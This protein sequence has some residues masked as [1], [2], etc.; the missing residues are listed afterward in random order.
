MALAEQ[1]AILQGI[2]WNISLQL[3]VVA[4]G[5]SLQ[6]AVVR[7]SPTAREEYLRRGY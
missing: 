5:T 4:C 6:Q 1:M 7:F 3:H 2:K